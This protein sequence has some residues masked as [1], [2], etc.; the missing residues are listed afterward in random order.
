M[1]T[2]STPDEPSPTATQAPLT[3]GSG[4]SYTVIVKDSQGYA[5][6]A[7]LTLYPGYRGSDRSALDAGWAAVGG[8][9]ADP[10]IDVNPSND[11]VTN[12]IFRTDTAYFVFGTLTIK[13][14]SNGFSPQPTTWQ[15]VGNTGAGGDLVTSPDA[16]IDTDFAVMGAGYSSGG[17]CDGL[18]TGGFMMNP[19]WNGS[20][21]QWG[22]VPIAIAI[23]GVYTPNHP[24]GNLK[25]INAF[26]LGE[27]PFGTPVT[28]STGKQRQGIP[29]PMPAGS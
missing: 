7:T 16:S 9:G 5:Q 14:N 13:N 19:K 6:E 15:W 25:D 8:T 23:S 21:N 10:C 4:N 28:D 2:S 12:Y 17:E 11:M 1:P 20:S 3:L 27:G 22:P 18:T 29:L 26:I 24:S